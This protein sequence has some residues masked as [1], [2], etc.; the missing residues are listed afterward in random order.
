MKNNIWLTLAM[1]L[2]IGIFGGTTW[3][4]YNDSETASGNRFQAWSADLWTQTSQADFEAGILYQ[5]DTSS[6]PGN[7]L[8][9]ESPNW[10]D[11]DWDYR[12]E[13]TIDHTELDADLTDF[14][15]LISIPSDTDLAL[16]PRPAAT[17][18]FLPLLTIPSN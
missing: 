8:L 5:V 10:Y 16:M 15:V 18:F 6:N 2:I 7:V 14:P 17:I 4:Y 3:A 11:I 9:A 12:K 1:L 13:I